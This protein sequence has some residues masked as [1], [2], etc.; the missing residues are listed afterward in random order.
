MFDLKSVAYS[1]PRWLAVRT[2]RALTLQ[3]SMISLT[4][5]RSARLAVTYT[6]AV[7]AS[8]AI[9]Q[10]GG[11]AAVSVS[12]S[13]P[14]APLCLGLVACFVNVHATTLTMYP[15]QLQLVTSQSNASV[16]LL[17]LA[18]AG[19]SLRIQVYQAA[20]YCAGSRALLQ[21]SQQATVTSANSS[22]P[23]LTAVEAVAM[24]CARNFTAVEYVTALNE[25][26]VSGGYA[27]NN[28]WIT[29]NVT[30]VCP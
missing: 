21:A 23:D 24:L 30:K 27:C 18:A 17:V 25:R 28:P 12:T 16:V 26:Y 10:D 20:L 8:L 6:V 9:G 7:L 14:G 15:Y 13:N 4:A 29:Y 1:F 2:Y 19:D 11:A 3:R 5:P 22:L